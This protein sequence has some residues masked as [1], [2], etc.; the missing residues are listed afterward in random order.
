MEE[1]NIVTI[2]GD[3]DQE[4][5]FEILDVI[6][7]GG[8]RYACITPNDEESEEVIIV[9]VIGYDEEDTC[10]EA[11]EDEKI[12]NAVFEEFQVRNQ[13]IFDFA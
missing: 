4:L 8:D 3:N 6:E 11:V 5:E 1:K 7:F 13:D 2:L 10:I 12:I 9:K